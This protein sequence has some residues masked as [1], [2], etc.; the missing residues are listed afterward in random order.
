MDINTPSTVTQTTAAAQAALADN[1]EDE[2]NSSALSSDFETFL[3]MLTVQM[4]T[5]IH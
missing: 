5:R 1:A 2:G 3:K 4:E